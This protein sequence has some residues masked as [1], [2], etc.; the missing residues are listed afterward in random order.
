MDNWINLVCDFVSVGGVANL[1]PLKPC[2]T[3]RS[4]LYGSSRVTQKYWNIAKQLTHDNH[5]G[6]LGTNFLHT[7]SGSPFQIDHFD[8]RK[9][10][11]ISKED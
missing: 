1:L 5:A 8:L 7:L 6:T 3:I 4:V 11:I 10:T 9:S 2:V